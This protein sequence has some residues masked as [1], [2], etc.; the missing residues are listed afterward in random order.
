MKN[1]VICTTHPILF[2]RM[3]WAKHVARMGGSR[4][5]YSALVEEPERKRI[6]GRPRHRWIFRKWDVGVRTESRW[7]RI[8]TK[9]QTK[10]MFQCFVMGNP[11]LLLM[12][13]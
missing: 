11:E 13:N 8:R 12:Q 6:L 10:N 5:I 1:L 9:N 2:R 3:R 4:G 7:L